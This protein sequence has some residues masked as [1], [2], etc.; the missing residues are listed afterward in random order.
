[1]REGIVLRPLIELKKNNGERIISKH[2]RDEFR[3]TET[4]RKVS[5]DRVQ[6]IADAKKIAQEW[7]TEMR[8]T[9]VLSKLPHATG[10][11]HT[12]DVIFAM[13]EDVE[14]EAAGEIIFSTDAKKSVGT[15]TA[16]L[17]KQRFK[18]SLGA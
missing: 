13:L 17:Y 11:E 14:R 9:H 3:E 7:V 10:M 8:L 1:M 2:K 16:T 5:P 4:V 12:R 6:V 18:D 15:R